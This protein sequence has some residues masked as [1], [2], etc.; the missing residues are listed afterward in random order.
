[1]KSGESLIP[2]ARH[3]ELVVQELEDEV[4]VYDL[5]SHQVHCLNRTAA[6]IWEHCDGKQTVRG[7]ARLLEQKLGVV[8]DEEVVWLGLR[9]L[10]KYHLLQEQMAPSAGPERISRRELGRR[11]GAVAALTLPLIISV[12][13]PTAAQAAT[14]ALPDGSPCEIDADCASNCCPANFCDPVEACSSLAPELRERRAREQ[15]ERA[16]RRRLAIP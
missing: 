6:L 12:V 3:N 7:L 8:T 16:R 15:R 5:K 10:N 2:K 11:L 9:Q 4:L 13:A 14:G 1:M